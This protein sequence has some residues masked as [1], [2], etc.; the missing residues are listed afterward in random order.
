VLLASPHPAAVTVLL[1]LAAAL[2]WGA[3]DF[4]GGLA[5]RRAPPSRVVFIA[6]GSS[7]VLLAAI[8]LR[9]PA[10]LSLFAILGGL[11]S[12]MVGGIALMVFYRALA[13]GAMGLSAALAGLLTAILPVLIAART[14]GAPAPLQIAGFTL[15]AAAIVLIAYAPPA[16]STSS[17]LTP[18]LIPA[19]VAATSN[20]PGAQP[21]RRA[22][23]FAT[24]AGVGFGL[25]LVWLHASAAAGRPAP[26]SST[27]A[28]VLRALMLSRLGGAAISL[29]VRLAARARHRTRLLPAASEP[30]TA[31][32]PSVA[33]LLPLPLLAIIAGLL[34]TGGN[35]F[36]MLASL[37]GRLDVAAVLSSLYPGGTIALAAIFLR[38]RATRLQAIGMATAL[39]AVALIAA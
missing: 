3:A 39:V 12:G 38:E 29:S 22:L 19:S 32:G 26:G 15:A 30:P 33:W 7:L 20:A 18:A 24:L 21:P 25:Q 27:F 14:Q 1:G 34:D 9:M 37:S 36:Y 13:L 35:G 10:I 28:P 2:T 17:A 8:S 4:A 5:T 16:S 31:A 11:L 23:L 6:H